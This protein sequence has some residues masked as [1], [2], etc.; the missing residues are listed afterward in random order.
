M[1]F[2]AAVVS[3]VLLGV[4]ASSA[5][6]HPLALKAVE[7]FE[8][9]EID[10]WSYTMTTTSREGTKVERHVAT[11][12]ERERWELLLTEGRKPSV[13]ER[14]EYR[15]E[16]AKSLERRKERRKDGDQDV[17]RSTITLLAETPDKATFRFRPTADDEEDEKFMAHVR[18]TLVVNKDGAWVERFELA[19]TDEI[20]PMAGVKV[21]EFNV[22]M[23]FE[24]DSS[25]GDVLPLSVVSRLRGRAF[26]VKSLDDDVKVMFSDFERVDQ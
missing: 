21:K 22:R 5:E 9:L 7:K 3:V 16:K 13:K 20:K 26:L 25:T 4:P 14:D 8:A 1:R 6:P 11:S 12:P 19:S 2:L 15:E 17:E 18:G 23:L 24:R 10:N